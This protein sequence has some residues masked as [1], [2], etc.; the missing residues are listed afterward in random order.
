MLVVPAKQR[1]SKSAAA[2]FEAYNSEQEVFLAP[3][4]MGSWR[5]RNVPSMSACVSS[6]V[7]VR[8]K[9]CSFGMPARLMCNLSFLFPRPDT[10]NYRLPSLTREPP[11]FGQLT[12]LKF[13]EQTSVWKQLWDVATRTQP[14]DNH[15]HLPTML[16]GI[17]HDKPT[18]VAKSSQKETVLQMSDF[19]VNCRSLRPNS[20]SPDELT[21]ALT[22]TLKHTHYW[23]SENHVNVY[24]HFLNG[25]QL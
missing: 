24:P 2:P 16:L 15:G 10:A 12:S 11:F 14:N 23:P 20:T 18:S 4:T 7:N 22:V 8:T 13:H 21:V 17:W 1:K 5:G 25:Y 6:C 19:R 3:Q 9:T